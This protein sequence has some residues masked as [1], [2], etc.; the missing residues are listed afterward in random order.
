MFESWPNASWTDKFSALTTDHCL[1]EEIFPN[2][3][4]DPLLSQLHADPLGPV[5][6]EEISTCPS[7][8]PCEEAAGHDEVF[9]RIPPSWTN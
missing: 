3:Q 7:A 1:S 6:P 5:A 9:P 4:L 2:T 8:L